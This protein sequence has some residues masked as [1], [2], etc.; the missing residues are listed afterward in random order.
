MIYIQH[1]LFYVRWPWGVKISFP[2]F[3]V[4]SQNFSCFHSKILKVTISAGVIISYR[5]ITGFSLENRL[6][7]RN[8]IAK[9]RW[10]WC[11]KI[12]LKM[13]LL[14]FKCFYFPS[15]NFAF[16]QFFFYFPSNIFPFLQYLF[17]YFLL[18]FKNFLLLSFK[19]FFL[20][21]F[22]YFL[23]LSF[24]YFCFPSNFIAFL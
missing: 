12:L 9:L 17:K 5:V 2:I 4:S 21:S 8:V 22:K 3:L 13:T 10:P 11:V 19:Y 18:S 20:L 6:P 24:K 23:L 7:I 1:E 15:N 14:S 16:L